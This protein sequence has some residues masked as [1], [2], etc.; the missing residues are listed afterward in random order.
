MKG[1][2]LGCLLYGTFHIPCDGTGCGIIPVKEYREDAGKIILMRIFHF[3]ESAFKTLIPVEKDIIPRS[4]VVICAGNRGVL[5]RTA[6]SED[7]EKKNR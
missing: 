2:Y 6:G 5:F 4:N 7:S 3:P 1:D